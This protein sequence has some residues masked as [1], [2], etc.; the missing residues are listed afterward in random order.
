MRKRRLIVRAWVCGMMFALTALP[1]GLLA[2]KPPDDP[3]K[4]IAGLRQ[5]TSELNKAVKDFE[6]HLDREIALHDRGYRTKK[7][8]RIPGADA[9]LV[10]GPA[11][12]VDTATRK[13]FAARMIAARR[14]GYA[15]APVADSDRIQAMIEQ[16]RT[17][18]TLAGDLTRRLL[19]VSAKDLS[20]KGAA[21]Q[22]L[23]KRE[24]VRVR[25]AAAEAAKRA[26]VA[27]PIP[28]P[29]ADS[30]EDQRE[31]A[32]DLMTVQKSPQQAPVLPIHFE[33]G[34]RITLVNEHFC[35]VTLTD[36]GLEDREGRHLFYQEEWV[37]RHG[38][39]TP[40]ST[41][42][43]DLIVSKRWAVAV[44]T[45]TGQHTLL[46]RYE[47]REFRGDFDDL[48]R[49]RGTDYVAAAKPAIGAAPSTTD[50][51]AAVESVET[52]RENL[53]DA[54]LG[55]KRRIREAMTAND[56]LLATQN[57]LALD[58]DLP[59]DLREN[60]FAIRG[61]LARSTHLIEA[62]NRVRGAA[63]QAGMDTRT[64]EALVAWV[65]GNALEQEGPAQDSRAL[66][67]VLHRADS[68]I[69]VTRALE[70]E[71]LS[72]LP[73]TAAGHEAQFPAFRNNMIVRLRGVG[74]PTDPNAPIHC[75]Q[76]IWRIATSSRG[77]REV[78]R[79]ITVIELH[80]ASGYQIPVS[81]DVKYYPIAA[82]EVLEEVFDENA[83]Q[84]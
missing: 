8:Q 22:K 2:Q 62:E 72:A 56:D 9:D 25:D 33:E 11:D 14:P 83:A 76:E 36:S 77:T 6:L 50:L 75:R 31:K 60:L 34:K 53:H 64:L 67:E 13:L 61:H 51:T 66:I 39:G 81:R 37:L 79:T 52:A 41:G 57:K 84:P 17:R 35:R 21:E 15:P 24:L 18:M 74:T 38:V 27:L 29:A 54:V 28:L 3:D 32:W 47:P 70:S 7:N 10:G 73:P 12:L 48:Y 78:R 46:R 80:P 68:G 82:D 30:P 42:E 43:S 69:D 63:E 71:A 16:A 5:I 45:T 23:K 20:L 55:F 19:V 1:V 59:N 26:F 58:D 65:N 4:I 49:F 44:N 40:G